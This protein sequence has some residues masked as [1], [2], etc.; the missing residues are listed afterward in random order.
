MTLDSDFLVFV[1]NSYYHSGT[2]YTVSHKASGT[3][4]TFLTYIW[5]DQ[6]ITVQY[7][8]VGGTVGK[9]AAGILPLDTQHI[10]N[11]I[12]YFGSNV[13]V[14]SLTKLDYDKRGNS[15]NVWGDTKV[16]YTTTDDTD[17][18]CYDD[19]YI[20]QTFASGSSAIDIISVKLRVKRTGDPGAITA[21]I[22]AVDGDSKPT[23][24]AL[25]SGTLD[26]KDLID[27]G[28][29]EWIVLPLTS[30]PLSASTTYAIVISAAGGDASNKYD[31]RSVG[32]GTYSD[33]NI[34]TSDD[35]GSSWTAGSGDALFDLYGDT[36]A[37]AMVD[38]LGM[39]DEVVLYGG[40]QSGDLRLNFQN[41]ES[42]I[43]RGT[44]IKYKSKWYQIDS[45]DEGDVWDV[46]YF[47]EATANQYI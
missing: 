35:A 14:R 22:Y 15:Q 37:F 23:G 39:E 18:A 4:I 5:D 20:A 41:T 43:A 28:D 6:S 36:D 32:T 13:V 47:I 31:V 21:G 38:V 24:S 46:D 11:E 30:Y 10:N 3:V 12:S 25:T 42:N 29:T 34:L 9:G 40:F 19:N 26:Y 1:N 45:I 16:S 17:N 7:T 44:K 27:D 33:G 8:P 2:D